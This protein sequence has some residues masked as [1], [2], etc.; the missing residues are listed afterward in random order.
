[1]EALILE[2]NTRGLHRYH[3]IDQE[4]TTLG[5]ALDND[6]ILSDPTVAPHHLKI[7]RY[8][9]SSYELVNLT[10]VNP[11][12]I[13]NQQL[14]T[15]VGENLPVNLEIGR[16]RAQLLRR[17]HDVPATRPLA[18]HGGISLLFGHNYWAVLL[19]LVCLCIGGLEFFFNAYNSVKWSNLFKFVLRE[20]ILTIGFFVLALAV[21]E[22]L[23]VNRWEIRQLV[24]SICLVYLLY[25]VTTLFS[26]ELSYLFSANWPAT[27]FHLAWY[28]VLLP[29]AIALYLIHISHLK[30]GRS[31][32]LAILIA[33]PI[34]VPSLLQSSELRSLLDDFTS[35]AKY[36]NNLSAWNWHLK[37][38]VTVEAFIKQAGELEPGEFAD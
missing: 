14:D 16:V 21:L 26:K 27:L 37:D 7:I 12:R 19:V 31:I 23:L 38:T 11:V 6:I 36:Q 15:L 2:I 18:G 1:M 5:R 17:D 25:Y 32:L 28:L 8:G 20:T 13:E 10:D 24:T 3:C 9:D 33:S 35:S 29:A 30:R 22:R 4:I 34:V